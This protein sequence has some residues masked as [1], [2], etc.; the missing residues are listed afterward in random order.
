MKTK[1]NNVSV[2]IQCLALSFLEVNSVK[3]MVTGKKRT[4]KKAHRK[5]AHRKKSAYVKKRMRK[6]RTRN[7]AR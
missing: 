2:T 6:E 7:E 3:N 5:K 4:G 1:G